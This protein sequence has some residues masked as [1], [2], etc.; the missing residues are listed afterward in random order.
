MAD[1]IALP[2]TGLSVKTDSVGD[3]HYQRIKITGG[4]A[5]GEEHIDGTAA[6]G[7]E[8]D[9]TRIAPLIEGGLTELVGI[10]EQVDQN[11]YSGSIGVALAAACSGEIQ[12]FCFYATE[13][14][15]G[16]VQ[17][18][19]GVLIIM[20]ADPSI[21]S[22]DT[23][24]TAA[25]RVTVIGQVFVTAGD[26]VTDASGGSAFIYNQPVAFHSLATLY[27]V[28]FH[29]DATSLNDAAGDDEQLEFNFHYQRG[30]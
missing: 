4:V 6:Y 27:F 1:D 13:D 20:D 28:W 2:G 11:D 8:V 14:G 18:S 15:T 3:K 9:A 25:E 21:A 10:N 30:A 24:M 26:W 17:D 5:E 22:G 23:A 19:A 12:Q 29:Q 7:L 16:A